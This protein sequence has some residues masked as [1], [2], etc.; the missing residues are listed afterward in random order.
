MVLL[1]VFN[2]V[3]I[4]LLSMLGEYVVRTLNAVSA[5]DTLPRRRAG[6]RVD[7]SPARRSAP[8]AAAR[9]TC[10]SLLDA[11]PEI[12]MARP[13]APGAEGVPLRRARRPRPRSGTAETYFA[14]ATDERAARREEHQLPRGPEAAGRAPRRA[15]RRRTIVVHAPRPGRSGPS[16]TGGSAPT[17]ASR[18][19]PLETALRE[20][21]DGRAAVG[22]RRAP[23]C[24][25]SP[26]SSAAATPSYLGRGS[27]AFPDDRRTCCSSR[28]CSTG[29]TALG[30]A[31][32]ARSAST[33]TSGRPTR[34]RSTR[35]RS[36]PR[37][38]PRTCVH[39]LRD[40]LP[41]QRPGAEPLAR[42][43]AALAAGTAPDPE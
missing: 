5:Q 22:P 18:P 4:A 41:R 27:T 21:L 20:N 42:A 11:H 34:E 13:A 35:A 24:R 43:A 12:T 10:T 14:H 1:S 38:C 7:A 3:T 40:V 2:G 16:P 29:T 28:S 31:L 39:A 17:T 36:R 6:A 23:R 25:R 30:D 32:R 19:R 15:R 37:R 33:R 8:S 9:P 26:T